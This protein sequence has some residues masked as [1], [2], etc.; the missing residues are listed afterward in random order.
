MRRTG[1]SLT[2]VERT[3]AVIRIDNGDA[4]MET[5]ASEHRVSVQTVRGWLK[6]WRTREGAWRHYFDELLP[7]E[8]AAGYELGD[9]DPAD[10]VRYDGRPRRRGALKRSKC[11][12]AASRALRL[13]RLQAIDRFLGMLEELPPA[14]LE[15]HVR[16]FQAL[17]G[18]DRDVFSPA[19][20]VYQLAAMATDEARAKVRR[21]VELATRELGGAGIGDV[22]A[23]VDR[24]A[25]I[26]GGDAQLDDVA[27]SI[28]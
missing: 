7:I 20:D 17:D 2:T 25:M 24:G 19:W 11:E 16:A 18:R 13:A 3:A 14:S 8:V 23:F 6:E 27:R 4:S 1:P 22:A 26:E 15:R 28:A 12:P 5:I 9:V 21:A 10:G